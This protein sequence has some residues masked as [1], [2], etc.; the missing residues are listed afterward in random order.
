V[1]VK[2]SASPVPL[3]AGAAEA[4]IRTARKRGSKNFF[5][6]FILYKN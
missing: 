6:K 4:V 5:I 3:G 1:G 2:S